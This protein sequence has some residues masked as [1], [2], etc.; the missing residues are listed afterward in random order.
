LGS[1]EVRDDDERVVVSERRKQRVLLALLL[2]RPNTVVRTS[3][4]LDELW[5]AD[6]FTSLA[7]ECGFRLLAEQAEITLAG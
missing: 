5:D 1:L 7:T 4:L 2:F 6:V 3:T